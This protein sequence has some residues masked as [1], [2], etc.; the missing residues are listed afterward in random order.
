MCIRDRAYSRG[1]ALFIDFLVHLSRIGIYS[2][3]EIKQFLPIIQYEL[4]T[5]LR[6]SPNLKDI[7]Q[8]IIDYLSSKGLKVSV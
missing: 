3:E 5:I 2:D 7:I 6:L 4:K 8:R 1:D